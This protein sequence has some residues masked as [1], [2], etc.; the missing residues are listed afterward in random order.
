MPPVRAF[1][2][3]ESSR[4]LLDALARLQSGLRSAPGGVAGRWVQPEIAHL[5]LKFLGDVPSERIADIARALDV[6]CARRAPFTLQLR[7][8]GCFPNT[9]RPRVV[10]AG[11]HEQS[12]ALRALQRDIELNLEA[13][14]YPREGRAFAPHLTL[15]RVRQGAAS[16]EIEAL[17]RSVAAHQPAADVSL[18]QMLVREVVLFSSDLRPEGPRYT[19]LHRA[20]LQS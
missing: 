8:L 18:A 17:G 5:T 11:V 19:P 20:A 6:T 12:G 1:V 4:A 15:A 9:R 13:L 3:I 14:G 7:G 16:V 10:W 2:A